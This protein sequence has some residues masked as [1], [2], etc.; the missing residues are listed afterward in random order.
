MM[1]I[2]K[3]ALGQ[4]Q[5]VHATHRLFTVT[6]SSTASSLP[7]PAPST[8]S[9]SDQDAVALGRFFYRN[10]MIN[11]WANHP[12]H[13]TTLQQLIMFGRSAR[14]N[15]TLLMQSAD[16]L[17]RELTIRI[18]HRL[19]DMQT[20]P[21]V[22]MSNEQLDSIYQF[23]WR[24]FETLR[25]MS[26]IES[27]EQNQHLI[28]VVTHLL[29]ERKSKLDLTA[30]ICRECIYYMEP[31]AV[32]LFLARMLRSQISR[33]VL[34]K[35]HIALSLMQVAPE[36][37]RTPNVVGMIDTQILVARSV[38]QSFEFAKSSLARTYG[39]DESDARMP[40]VEIFGDLQA[41][42]A[43]LPAHLEFIVLELCKVSMQATMNHHTKTGQVPPIRILIVDSASKDEVIIRISDLGGGLRSVQSTEADSKP[44]FPTNV[45][46][47]RGPSL[48]PGI[49]SLPPV[50]EAED[51][52]LWSF[53]NLGK[54]LE[55]MNIQL[56]TTATLDHSQLHADGA[57][58]PDPTSSYP[59]GDGLMRLSVLNMDSR[60]G[61]PIV[62]L[63][64]ELFGGKLEFRAMDG[65]GTDIYL[66]LPKNGTTKELHE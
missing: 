26:K 5:G 6:R 43:Y 36:A 10:S 59:G 37:K 53:H 44:R 7:I 1:L 48:L 45:T 25:R 15:R 50:N 63:Y 40:S 14:R 27:D 56:D 24:T 39:W 61:L 49:S 18:A 8:A 2:K 66:R 16:Y 13:R 4:A 54:E 60:S 58:T 51:T 65:Y 22:A 38:Q 52:L 23:Y 46:R 28:D 12:A 55:R 11:E 31:E 3:Q 47:A 32:N 29:S 57:E 20:I 19:R 9:A 42:I 21:F 62:K 33:E 34:A 41:Q 30:G 17:R 35:Q 64:A